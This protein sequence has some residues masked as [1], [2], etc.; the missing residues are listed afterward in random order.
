MRVGRKYEDSGRDMC[1]YQ[2]DSATSKG[3]LAQLKTYNLTQPLMRHQ[4][5]KIPSCVTTLRPTLGPVA[6]ERRV[7]RR[8]RRSATT[9]EQWMLRLLSMPT[10][11]RLYIPSDGSMLQD[12]NG[13]AS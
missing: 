2:H 6:A 9:L 11:R 8:A 12:V 1:Q 7:V 13:R 4:S 5:S 10:S 3:T